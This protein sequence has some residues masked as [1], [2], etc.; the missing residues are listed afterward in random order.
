MLNQLKTIFRYK[1][2][3]NTKLKYFLL[4]FNV[5]ILLLLEQLE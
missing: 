1:N 4:G 5:D 3:L 2:S